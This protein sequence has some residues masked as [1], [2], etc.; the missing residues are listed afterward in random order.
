MDKLNNTANKFDQIESTG[1][2]TLQLENTHS[3]LI[4][5]IDPEVSGVR[6][7]QIT[8]SDISLDNYIR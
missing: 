5:S 8:F 6:I 2:G 1:F 4:R 7:I 3:F